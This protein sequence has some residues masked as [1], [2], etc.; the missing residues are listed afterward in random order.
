[1]LRQK[2]DIVIR[3]IHGIFIIL[4][5]CGKEGSLVVQGRLEQALGDYLSAKGLREVAEPH[6]SRL[7]YPDDADGAQE[8]FDKFC[9]GGIK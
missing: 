5:D 3:D 1:M 8:L 7:T 2:N 6:F 4:N 9:S